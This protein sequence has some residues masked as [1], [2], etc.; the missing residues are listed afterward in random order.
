MGLEDQRRPVQHRL[1]C[2]AGQLARIHESLSRPQLGACASEPRGLILSMRQVYFDHQASTPVL[3]AVFEAMAPWFTENF[4]SASALHHH[5][6]L[7]RE[8]LER[9]R[10][11][12][13]TLN[14]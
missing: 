7:A 9:A 8:A 12:I 3:P 11:Q 5:G 10:E 6:V 13:A 4:G 1:R 14:N 2:A